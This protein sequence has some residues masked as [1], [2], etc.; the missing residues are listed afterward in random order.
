MHEV[1]GGHGSFD[2]VVVWHSSTEL[3]A[4]FDDELMRFA[5]LLGKVLEYLLHGSLIDAVVLDPECGLL[6]LA[7]AEEFANADLVS[8]VVAT[9]HSDAEFLEET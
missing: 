3:H 2:D 5:C 9:H 1:V 7:D 6:F 4:V 8:E